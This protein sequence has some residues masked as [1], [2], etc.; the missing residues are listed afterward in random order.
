MP[1][2]WDNPQ[3]NNG[4]NPSDWDLGTM[5]ACL[6]GLAIIFAIAIGISAALG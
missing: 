6:V 1:D 2:L 4:H 5:I 3:K